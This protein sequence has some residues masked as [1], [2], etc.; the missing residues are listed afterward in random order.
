MATVLWNPWGKGKRTVRKNKY[1]HK[2]AFEECDGEGKWC[3]QKQSF[4]M[5]IDLLVNEP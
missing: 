4:Q 1:A 3:K 2:D 5:F